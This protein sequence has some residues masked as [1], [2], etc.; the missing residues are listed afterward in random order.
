M[1][2]R[3][4]P[5]VS[6][7]HDITVLTT[8]ARTTPWENAYPARRVGGDGVRVHGF[9]FSSTQPELFPTSATSL[10]RRR[11]AAG[12]RGRWFRANGPMRRRCSTTSQAR[13]WTT[14]SCSSGL[15]L[16]AD[17]F[18]LPLV[19]ERRCWCD[20]GR[21][22]SGRFRRAAGF[23]RPARRY[24][25]S[26][27]EEK[28]LVSTRAE[29]AAP[30]AS[31]NGLEPE[32]DRHPSR[33]ADRSPRHPARLRAVSRRVDRNKGCATLLE[34]SRNTPTPGQ[35]RSCSPGRRPAIPDQPRIRAPGYVETRAA[36]A[37]R[38]TRALI[39]PSPTKA[40]AIVL[41]EAWNTALQHWSALR[42]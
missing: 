15:P 14:T 20:R 25:F 26:Q 35:T 27:P 37:S 16:R 18:G 21:R 6:L 40:S 23:L 24:L 9:P 36:R 32:H 3:Q 38:H 39:V 10:R 41:L 33:D 4:R 30:R 1:H 2:C 34:Y 19:A 12:T 42:V 22:S 5:R 28:A 13:R 29:R 17:Y 31:W 11:L 8:C 7:P